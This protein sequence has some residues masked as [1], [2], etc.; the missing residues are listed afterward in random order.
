A[1]A[2][3]SLVIAPTPTHAATTPSSSVIVM[4]PALNLR[5]GPRLSAPILR[6]LARGAVLRV[7]FYHISW[8]AVITPDAL[9]GYVYLYDVRPITTTTATIA[10]TTSTPRAV[11][12]PPY[13]MVAVAGAPLRFSPAI[14]APT[15]IV[16][17]RHTTL[18]LLGVDRTG[19]WA[20]VVTR[21]GRVGWIA[22][23]MTVS[24]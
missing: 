6:R 14:V 20:R 15:L 4:T 12:Q 23:F 24:I 13:V 22:R 18:A 21:A 19:T 5:A 10:T 1:T 16:L 3:T 7:L 8:V 9:V 11:F 2:M 17:P